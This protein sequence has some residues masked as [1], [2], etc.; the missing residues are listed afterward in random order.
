MSF[1][2]SEKTA[3]FKN[4][5]FAK[6]S[7]SARNDTNFLK[8]FFM[9]TLYHLIFC[10]H[11]KDKAIILIINDEAVKNHYDTN[12]CHSRGSGNPG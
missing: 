1:R 8:Y 12:A 10:Q 4:Y 7:R 2:P 11:I 5:S 9:I 6:I 3:G